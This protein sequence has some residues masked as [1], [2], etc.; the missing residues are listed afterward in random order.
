MMNA[1]WLL[2]IIA[3]LVYAAKADSHPNDNYQRV[4]VVIR[5]NN[6]LSTDAYEP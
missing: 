4:A 5:A 6:H 1:I 3:C 2:I